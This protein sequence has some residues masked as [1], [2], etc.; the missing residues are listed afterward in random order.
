MQREVPEHEKFMLFCKKFF[1]EHTRLLRSKQ[2]LLSQMSCSECSTDMAERR[3]TAVA[4]S[5]TKNHVRSTG[6]P[7]ASEMV[8][9]LKISGC[10]KMMS[11]QLFIFGLRIRLSLILQDI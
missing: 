7:R 2:M 11:S 9:S 3:F 6:V 4:G 10:L 8:P 1:K 5:V